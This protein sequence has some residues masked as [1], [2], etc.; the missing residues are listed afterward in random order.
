MGL[1]VR[2]ADRR[3]NGRKKMEREGFDASGLRPW[4]RNPSQIRPA[5]GTQ[6]RAKLKFWAQTLRW[7]HWL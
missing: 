7:G 4:S 2:E 5:A 6:N 3:V 1:Q